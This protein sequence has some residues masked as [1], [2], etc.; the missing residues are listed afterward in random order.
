MNFEKVDIYGFKSFADKS[1]IKF[2]KL[3]KG[4]LQLWLL[5]FGACKKSLLI[6]IALL[7]LKVSCLCFTLGLEAGKALVAFGTVFEI[8][9]SETDAPQLIVFILFV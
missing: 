6:F 8:D 3:V 2:G 5:C 7:M 9:F 4:Y 1:E